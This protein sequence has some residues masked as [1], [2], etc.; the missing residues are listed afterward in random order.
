[1]PK[2]FHFRFRLCFPSV[3]MD[4][5]P[6]WIQSCTNK[7]IYGNERRRDLCLNFFQNPYYSVSKGPF[8]RCSSG[9]DFLPQQAKSVHMVQLLQPL[10]S[11]HT[12][13]LRQWCRYQLDSKPILCGSC[14]GKVTYYVM[15]N[16]LQLLQLHRMGLQ[17][18]YLWHQCRNHC[19]KCSYE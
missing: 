14:S 13:R 8:T 12:V 7:K 1:M 10:R 2:T 16:I 19:R 3:E 4:R 17:P 18:I 6:S 9:C 11:I 15:Q 5:K